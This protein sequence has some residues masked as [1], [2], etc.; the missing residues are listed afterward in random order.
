MR[1][2]VAVEITDDGIIEMIKKIQRELAGGTRFVDPYKMHFT[3]QFLGEVGE[4]AIDDVRK[5]L[6]S[7]RFKPFSVSL[8]GVG[9]F[10]SRR[11]PRVVWVGV[12][13]GATEL[14][15]LA[16]EINRALAPLGLRPDKP[17]K[18]HV[19]ILRKARGISEKL[20]E[21]SGARFGVQEVARFKLK[22][23]VLTPDGPIYSDLLEVG[24]Q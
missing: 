18:A 19:T 8:A 12:D 1:S 22:K 15:E 10:P 16:G 3:L 4:Q 24:S 5:A 13:E 9:A 2:F 23:S 7:V 17:F 20:E 14:T 21:L 6:G 11:S